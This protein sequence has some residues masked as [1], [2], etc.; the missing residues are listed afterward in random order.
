ML[1]RIKRSFGEGKERREQQKA[2]VALQRQL[3]AEA[4]AKERRRR[5]K[6]QEQILEILES[7]KVPNLDINLDLPFRMQRNERWLVSVDNVAYAEMRVKREIQGR[8]AGTSVRVAKGVSFRLGA[9]RGTPVETDVLTPRGHG[10]LAV[11]TKHLF[12]Q[13]ERS[14]RIPLAKIVSA[15]TLP[16]QG[17]EIVR[18]RASALPEIFSL[19]DDDADFIVRLLHLLP[20][21]DFGRGTPQ[22]EP[23]DTYLL[24]YGD[25]GADDMLEQD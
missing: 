12:F 3:A 6:F 18:E 16:S 19:D 21:V 4:A 24:P 11:S 13:G 7:G 20:D 9:S 1:S 14:F 8:S 10:L 25:L 22:V 17:M 15:Q 23:A 2:E 5:L